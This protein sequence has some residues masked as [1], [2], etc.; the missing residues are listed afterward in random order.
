MRCQNETLFV[1]TL[2]GPRHSPQAVQP[3]APEEEDSDVA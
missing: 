2:G 1:G 3:A